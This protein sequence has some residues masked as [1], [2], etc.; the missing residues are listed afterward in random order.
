MTANPKRLALAL[1]CCGVAWP[2]LAQEPAPAPG[3]A[4]GEELLA[5]DRSQLRSEIR[6]RFDAA[7]ALT[8]DPAVVSADNPRYIWA[9]EAKVQCGIALG[10]LKSGYK[11]PIS[12]PKCAN[13][14]IWM[15]RQPEYP[16]VAPPPPQQ[17]YVPPEICNQPIAGTV[18]FE[19]NSAVPQPDAGQTIA[20]V[21]NTMQ[22]CGR[23]ALAVTGHADRSGPDSYN[24]SLSVSRASAVADM[25]ANA[26]I[27]RNT[28]SVE[29]RG[30]REPRVPT[31]DGVR[32]PQ[33][34]RVE[35]TAK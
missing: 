18:F 15:N 8:R 3:Q 12:I 4:S 30:E 22:A 7:V 20:Y 13:A 32:N 6:S 28:L 23:K 27:D 11:D 10:Y 14:A 26:G 31:P 24:Q 21:A 9:S 5:L 17:V 29:G 35:I 19:W 2:A 1:A 16:A 34:R 25:L 33:N